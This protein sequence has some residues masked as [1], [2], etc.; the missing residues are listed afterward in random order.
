[1]DE[2][3]PQV[4]RLSL[5]D[6]FAPRAYVR[7]ALV[8]PFDNTK[9]V[10]AAER[11]RTGLHCLF[12]RYP[13]LAGYFVIHVNTK[14]ADTLQRDMEVQYSDIVDSIGE[15]QYLVRRLSREEFPYTYDELHAEGMPG[16]KLLNSLLARVPHAP[17]LDQRQPVVSVTTNFIEGGL[18]LHVAFLHVIGD[19]TGMS[20]LL[21]EWC[22][23]VRNGDHPQ[24]VERRFLED[25]RTLIRPAE[26]KCIAAF[27]IGY[28]MVDP[29]EGPTGINTAKEPAFSRPV[30]ARVFTFSRK[31]LCELKKA[32]N[33]IVEIPDVFWISANDCINA[34]LWLYV[35]RARAE[36]IMRDGHRDTTYFTPVNLRAKLQ[37][38]ESY[39]GNLTLLA[40][41]TQPLDDFVEL[42]T[43]GLEMTP[44]NGVDETPDT[45]MQ[46][47]LLD[48]I[49]LK[50][51]MATVE[52]HRDFVILTKL[53]KILRQSI[54]NVDDSYI[55]ER[56]SFMSNVLPRSHLVKWNFHNYFGRDFFCTSWVDFGAD[57]IW[58]IPGTLSEYPT[59]LRKPYVP[60]DGSSVVLP[61]R[62]GRKANQ[63]GIDGGEGHDSDDGWIEEPGPYE[64]WVQLREDYLQELCREDS[65]GGWA[66]RIA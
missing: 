36:E 12:T 39:H 45:P 33:R 56:F 62:R 1:M 15:P 6:H 22:D 57:T 50:L 20:F 60:D 31:R 11:I 63:D 32:F 64:V 3:E 41:V 9:E 61:R 49:E 42:S 4:M 5:T 17:K 54:N 51:K 23:F 37:D 65:L 19:G 66:D 55:Q 2:S 30:G 35:T 53:V 28:E 21:H 29:K 13:Y 18:I 26:D 27:P 59:W 43:N 44:T 58:K 34:M 24:T 52:D 25:R 10:E 8:W 38:L 47:M 14:E 40:Q 46:D 48:P 7:L 16:S